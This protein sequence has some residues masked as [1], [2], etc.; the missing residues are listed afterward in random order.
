MSK[1]HMLLVG[2]VHATGW[3][4][5]VLLCGQAGYPPL[6][7]ASGWVGLFSAG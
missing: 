3:N 4:C 2:P 6:V 5:R 1:T 7:V